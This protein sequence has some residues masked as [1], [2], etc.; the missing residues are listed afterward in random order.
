MTVKIHH[1]AAA[2]R[3]AA[4]LEHGE[5]VVDYEM[6][7]G[8]TLDLTRTFV[9]EDLRGEGLAGQVVRYALDWARHHGRR[10]IAT[11]P[12]VARFIERHPEYA[13]LTVRPESSAPTIPGAS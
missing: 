5:A 6:P 4:E 3:F 11:C 13:E 8:G 10:V 2:R 7:D 9:S 1:D 12:Y